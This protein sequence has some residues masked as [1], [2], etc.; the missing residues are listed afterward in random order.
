[1]ISP[2]VMLK[3]AEDGMTDNTQPLRELFILTKHTHIFLYFV[4]P[5][6]SRHEQVIEQSE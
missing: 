1:M 2:D 5:L 3:S 4:F 6:I